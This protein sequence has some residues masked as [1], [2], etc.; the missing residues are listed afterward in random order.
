MQ[1][2]H[3]SLPGERYQRIGLERGLL[4][5]RVKSKIYYGWVVVGVSF[6]TM[7]LVS[8]IGTLFQLFYQALKEE[9]HWSHGSISGI[10][11]VHQFLN[12]AVSPLVGWLL[13][14][15]GPRRIMPIGALVIG[16]ALAASSQ[17]TALWQLYLTFGVVAALGVS[18]LHSVPNTAIASNWFI[19]NRG[20]AIGIVISGG[21][22]GQLWLTPTT[23]WFILH[24]GWRTAYLAL[25]VLIFV[26]PA[27]LISLFQY[28]KPADKG[29]V[30]YGE[31]EGE[32][33]KAKREVVVLNPSWAEKTWTL[34]LAI[35][36]YRF[37][38]VAAMTVCFS[39]GF[40]L[41]SSQLFVLTQEHAAFHVQSIIV[42]FILGA[43]GLHKGF[44]KMF[45]GILSDRIGRESTLSMSIGLMLVGILTLNRMQEQP[46][47]WLL[48]VAVM[49]FGI[50]YGISLPSI[51]AAFAD[52]FQGPRFGSILGT[53]T[54][55]GLIGGGLGT[56]MGGRLRDITGGYQT[57]FMIAGVSFLAAVALAWA[58]RPGGIRVIRRIDTP[59]AIERPAII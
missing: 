41:V 28:H 13:D 51:M 11:A 57:N 55:G 44:A 39:F 49:L 54:L 47:A 10:Y 6:A 53:L 1:C 31:T 37:W 20:A 21:G 43:E 30:P 16:I 32:K 24:L 48:Y 2:V 19:R 22:F 9:F 17:I 59:G 12:G 8:P 33:Q 15:Y 38:A 25:A 29:L 35:R 5:S 46:S 26:V 3:Q 50:G 7:S 27:T 34:G 4:R 42:A 36:T 58:A 56:S 18:L 14:R 40:F 52:L 23:Q 45:G